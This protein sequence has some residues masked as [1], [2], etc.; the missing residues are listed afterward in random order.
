[1]SW[2]LTLALGIQNVSAENPFRVEILPTQAFVK[3][4]TQMKVIFVVPEGHHLYVD[5]LS[6]Q[7]QTQVDLDFQSAKFP[8]GTL[9]KDPANP[10]DLREVYF[11]T[12]AV[13]L[14]VTSQKTGVFTSNIRVRYQGCKEGLCYMPKE[15]DISVSLIVLEPKN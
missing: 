7:P 4:E 8:T 6:V 14:P 2:L 13:L 1:M 10:S 11:E 15:E 12:T 5:M 3:Q 9:K